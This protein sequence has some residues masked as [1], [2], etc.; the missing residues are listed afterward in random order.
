[1]NIHPSIRCLVALLLFVAVMAIFISPVVDI[2]DT[3]MRANGIAQRIAMS[4]I[5]IAWI[6]AGIL[7]NIAVVF[8]SHAR[9]DCSF[10]SA[11]P[12]DL[13]LPLLC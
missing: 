6:F 13:N 11:P 9:E 2:P 3:T 8:G 1:M 10:D 7:P 4:I 12:L 5:A